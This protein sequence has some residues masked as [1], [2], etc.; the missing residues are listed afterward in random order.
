MQQIADMA[1]VFKDFATTAT[2]E[3]A[4][5]FFEFKDAMMPS[6]DQAA[7]FHRTFAER[8]TILLESFEQ[9]LKSQNRVAGKTSRPSKSSVRVGVGV[10]LV[11]DAPE[12]GSLG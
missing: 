2:G 12:L 6:M 11:Q 1:R 9:W 10:Y 3:R 5:R 8:G 4:H 7:L